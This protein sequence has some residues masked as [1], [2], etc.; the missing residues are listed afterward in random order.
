MSMIIQASQNGEHAIRSSERCYQIL[1]RM[2]ICAQVA[3]GTRLREVEWSE[4]LQ[5]QRAALREAMVLLVHDGLLLRRDSGGFFTPRLDEIDIDAIVDVRVVLETGGVKLT[6]ERRLPKSAFQ[7]V[8]AVCE[9]LEKCHEAG[10][11]TGFAEADFLFHQKLL[12]LSGNPPLIQ[13]FSHSAQMIFVAT[14]VTDAAQ[15]ANEIATIRDHR[16]I[17]SLVQE[18]QADE[19]IS[20]IQN[21]L[22]KTKIGLKAAR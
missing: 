7:P 8:E 17:L 9:M 22:L 16:E 14:P 1:R 19:A 10:M 2:L 6:C 11:A 5:V 13:M 20:R 12:E 18:G 4:K 21:H 15:R 3:P